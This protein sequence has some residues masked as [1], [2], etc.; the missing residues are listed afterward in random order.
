MQSLDDSHVSS[1]HSRKKSTKYRN[2]ISQHIY[3]DI[4]QLR[5]P[6]ST[7]AGRYKCF[8]YCVE[9]FSFAQSHYQEPNQKKK[10][11]PTHIRNARTLNGRAFRIVQHAARAVHTAQ[12]TAYS[13]RT[14]HSHN[15]YAHTG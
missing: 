12:Y 11:K 1:W 6:S 2:T 9:Q 4:R 5:I 10:K 7:K 8:Q 3:P 15:T 13:C 14:I